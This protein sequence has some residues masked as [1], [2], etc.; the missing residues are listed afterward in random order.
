MKQLYIYSYDSCTQFKYLKFIYSYILYLI[1]AI[2][3]YQNR[4][5]F[6]TILENIGVIT[7]LTE[8]QKRKI[9]FHL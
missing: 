9:I 2:F 6:N 8:Y 4:D 3:S 7:N 5:K 1:E